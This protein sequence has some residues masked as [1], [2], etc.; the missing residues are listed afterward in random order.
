MTKEITIDSCLIS[1]KPYNGFRPLKVQNPLNRE[2]LLD[3]ARIYFEDEAAM[4]ESRVRFRST[5][6]SGVGVL[7]D[8]IVLY[9]GREHGS[10]KCSYLT[11]K[12]VD[13]KELVDLTTEDYMEVIK[14]VHMVKN[15]VPATKDENWGSSS[16]AKQLV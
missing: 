1:S 8:I 10:P 7:F 16:T 3:A 6:Q 2:N 15:R 12:L 4:K 5:E 13:S 9:D 11:F 14:A